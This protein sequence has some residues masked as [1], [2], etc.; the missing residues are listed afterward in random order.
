MNDLKHAVAARA[1]LRQ[2]LAYQIIQMLHDE[3][4][5]VAETQLI[6]DDVQ[7]LIDASLSE[8]LLPVRYPQQD[9]LTNADML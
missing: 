9:A 7:K 4:M 2:Q 8:L 1:M 3:K 5:S 6:L